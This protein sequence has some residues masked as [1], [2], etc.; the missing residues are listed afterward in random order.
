MFEKLK[1][2]IAGI[3]A[4]SAVR[5]GGEPPARARNRPAPAYGPAPRV[6]GR[7]PRDRGQASRCRLVVP[8]V[9]H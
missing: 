9:H 4:A 5:H 3:N 1:D 2:F 7:V 6:R 8:D